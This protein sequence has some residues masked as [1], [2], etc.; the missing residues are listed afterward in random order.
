[1]QVRQRMQEQREALARKAAREALLQR[2]K[3]NGR[4]R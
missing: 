2:A 3:A 1:M 4:R